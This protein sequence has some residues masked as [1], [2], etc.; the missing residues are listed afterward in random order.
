L[1]LRKVKNDKVAARKI[2]LL[3]KFQELKATNIPNEDI[4]C[5]R[6]LCRQYY[7]LN[8]ELTDYKNRLTGVIDQLM[9]NFKDVF[10]DICSKALL[11]S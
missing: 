7:K 9:L 2:A 11:L 10:S 8:D 4:E 5:L 6:S 1:E 3:Y